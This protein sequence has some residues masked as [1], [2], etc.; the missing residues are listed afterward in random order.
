VTGRTCL[1]A[2]PLDVQGDE[3]KKEAARIT[4]FLQR[5]EKNPKK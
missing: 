1:R 3:W 5:K 2:I 4:M